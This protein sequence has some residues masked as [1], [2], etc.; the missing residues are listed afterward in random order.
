MYLKLTVVSLGYHYLH[1]HLIDDV[2]CVEEKV[3]LELLSEAKHAQLLH[4]DI[5]SG[6]AELV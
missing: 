3:V 2:V 4:F 1:G 6:T 5:S